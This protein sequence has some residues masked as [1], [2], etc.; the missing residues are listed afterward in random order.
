MPFYERNYANGNLY[1][2]FTIIF[3]TSLDKSQVESLQ[4]VK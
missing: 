1:I 3:P 4:K 2:N